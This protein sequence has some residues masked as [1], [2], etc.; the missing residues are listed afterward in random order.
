MEETIIAVEVVNF[1]GVSKRE[2]W[3]GTLTGRLTCVISDAGTLANK[4]T[5]PE[6]S[7]YTVT[8]VGQ[9]DDQRTFSDQEAPVITVTTAAIHDTS[10]D[11]T[12][13]VT[14]EKDVTLYYVA[15]PVGADDNPPLAANVTVSTQFV[16]NYIKNTA[17]SDRGEIFD[18]EGQE[19]I[20]ARE[21]TISITDLEPS[22]KYMIYFIAESASG[23]LTT[24][25]PAKYCI[26]LE[27]NEQF[28][29]ITTIALTPPEFVKPYKDND[30]YVIDGGVDADGNKLFTVY[31]DKPADIYWT[32]CTDTN[33]QSYLTMVNENRNQIK[34]PT[35]NAGSLIATSGN[36]ASPDTAA[37]DTYYHTTIAVSGLKYNT[38]YHFFA[39]AVHKSQQSVTSKDYAHHGPFVMPD[40]TAPKITSVTFDSLQGDGNVVD[41]VATVTVNFDK[42]LYYKA[43]SGVEPV[44]P[45]VI[46]SDSKYMTNDTSEK[47][48][49][50]PV[51]GLTVLANGTQ[52]YKD[53]EFM[54]NAQPDSGVTSITF[55]IKNI[56][57]YNANSSPN[58]T[59]KIYFCNS[60]G[61]VAG[62]LRVTIEVSP[63][64]LTAVC[65][66][67]FINDST[68]SESVSSQPRQ[69]PT[70]SND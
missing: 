32:I 64:D 21:N 29:E 65:K 18:R 46:E 43:D 45:A 23:N 5:A 26:D 19:C 31:T 49:V 22:T 33:Y 30:A 42:V 14:N 34:E 13:K 40:Q 48:Q 27:G 55:Y 28:V 12:V 47:W 15:V 6:K 60:D 52:V 9:R 70:S 51:Q 50:A 57:T 53:R 17:S 25:D 59:S 66:A 10:A 36:I 62:Q 11:I 3:S 1:N 44:T 20:W 54:I 38:D 8:T 61:I 7:D 35:S 56:D 16:L 69:L 41:S 2:T 37:N 4:A 63:T 39:L 58:L 67:C 24:Y 68:T